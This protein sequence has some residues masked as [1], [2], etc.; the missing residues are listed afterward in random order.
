MYCTY[1]TTYEG[2]L[3]PPYYIGSSSVAR[4][5]SG[6]HG[7]VLSKK[8]KDIW[9]SELKH[10]PELFKT[11]IIETFLDREDALKAELDLQIKYDVVKSDKYIN[12][13]LAQKDGFFGMEKSG[14]PL[15]SEHKKKISKSHIGVSRP[16][17]SEILRGRK[18]PEQSSLMK[19][20]NNPMY[21]K[22]HPNKG[23]KIYQPR[24][25]CTKCGFESTRS[26]ISRFHNEK[27][28]V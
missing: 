13:A 22:E 10:H 20:E 5:K 21:G 12:M 11:E 18:R 28:K 14:I 17:H 26:V 23:K 25:V 19:G 27:C 3:L 6:Y 4:V 1:I 24:S 16:Y 7:T 15:S 8:Y 9:N 2:H